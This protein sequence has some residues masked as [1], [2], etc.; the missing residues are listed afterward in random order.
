[1]T[2]NWRDWR[3]WVSLLMIVGV[4]GLIVVFGAG[5]GF[6]NG[7]SDNSIPMMIDGIYMEF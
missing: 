5:K 4:L 3:D 1:M 7:S 2:F 6:N